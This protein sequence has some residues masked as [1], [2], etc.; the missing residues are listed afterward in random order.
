M[1]HSRLKLIGYTLLALAAVPWVLIYIFYVIAWA[2]DCTIPD[3]KAC[4]ALGGWIAELII[5][6]VYLTWYILLSGPLVFVG[7]I[8]LLFVKIRQGR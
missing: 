2:A 6:A 4:S 1:N 7:M 3:A 8:I 5:L